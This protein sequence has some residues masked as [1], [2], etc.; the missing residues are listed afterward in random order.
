MSFPLCRCDNV[1][2]LKG[3]SFFLVVT[4]ENLPRQNAS[5]ISHNKGSNVARSLLHSVATDLEKARGYFGARKGSFV[6]NGLQRP[7]ELLWDTRYQQDLLAPNRPKRREHHGSGERD[8]GRVSS[9]QD[10]KQG[11]KTWCSRIKL[12]LKFKSCKRVDLHGSPWKRDGALGPTWS[13]QGSILSTNG[14]RYR[15]FSHALHIR[16]KNEG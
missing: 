12:D 4:A 2:S 11:Q 6:A 14:K 1:L 7:S 3:V 9:T 15:S 13:S 16:M 8:G 10:K 5:W